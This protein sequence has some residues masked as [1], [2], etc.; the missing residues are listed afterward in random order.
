MLRRHQ[1]KSVGGTLAAA[2][3]A[4][5]LATGAA[6]ARDFTPGPVDGPSEATRDTVGSEAGTI[7]VGTVP[8]DLND[9]D[10]DVAHVKCKGRTTICADVMDIGFNDNTFHVSVHCVAP[11][12]KRGQG[13]LELAVAP[14]RQL[15]ELAC[16]SGCKEALVIYQADFNDFSDS[17]YDSLISCGDKDF[18][19]GFPKVVQ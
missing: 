9:P 1:A 11:A 17:N 5:A 4:L 18:S 7:I 13:E 15:S 6:S 3:L 2:G 14:G 19:P 16:V 12:K 10:V 8:S